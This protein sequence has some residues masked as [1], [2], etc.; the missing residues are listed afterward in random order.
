MTELYADAGGGVGSC[1]E[2]EKM[3][4]SDANAASD[5]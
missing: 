1:G 2:D 5:S 3:K 4:R